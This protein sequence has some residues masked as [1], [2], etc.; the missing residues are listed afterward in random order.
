MEYYCKEH[1]TA[2]CRQNSTAGQVD[3]AT[4][5]SGLLGASQLRHLRRYVTN[6][7]F[8][9]LVVSLIHSRLDC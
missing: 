5:V 6:N 3:A 9:R 7:G 4:G 1:A 2:V 8:R